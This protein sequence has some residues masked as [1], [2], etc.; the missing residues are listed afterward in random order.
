MRAPLA[1]KIRRF[2]AP[3][4]TL[5]SPAIMDAR[6]IA[7]S[8]PFF[9]LLIALELF[10]TRKRG[11]RVFGFH[12]SIGSLSCGVGQQAIGLITAAAKAAGYALVY[13][14]FHLL[15]IS[16][17]SPVAWVVLFLAVD[18]AYYAYHWASHRVNFL[19]ATHAVHHQSEEYNLT[20][21]LRQSWFTSFTSWIFYLPLAVIGFPTGMF[22]L[23]YTLNTLYQFWIHTRAVDRIGLFEAFLNTPSHHRVH[24]GVD[25]AYIDKNYAGV[26]IVWDRLFGTFEREGREPVYGT[27]KPLASFNP[28][29]ANIEPWVQLFALARRARRL[30]DKVWIFLGPPEWRPA[31]LGGVVT[32]PDVSRATQRK[33]EAVA[34]RGLNVYVS[35]AFT[36]V[37]GG[38]TALLAFQSELGASGQALAVASILFGLLTPGGLFEA[39]RWAVPVEWIR[40]GLLVAFA[41]WLTRDSA[42]QIPVVAGAA[43]VALGL[44]LWVGRYRRRRPEQAVPVDRLL[45]GAAEPVAIT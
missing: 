42:S 32:I 34:P 45:S 37:V 31:D 3:S 19:W 14:R 24:H 39:R 12:D 15:A 9:F 35:V 41:A 10:V 22:V 30:R 2:P 25:P 23:V 17:R 27:V 13:E 7:L 38:I 33:Y 29:W 20:T 21:A 40:L 6:A 4:L 26:F 28:F 36:L 18:L 43:V 8:I 11:E 16:P 5:H 44:S 1:G